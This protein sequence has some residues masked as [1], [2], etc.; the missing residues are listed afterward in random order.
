[1]DAGPD[2]IGWHLAHHHDITVSRATISRYL[3]KAGLVAPERR[4]APSR[5]TSG[6]RRRCPMRPGS[7]TSP[8]TG[9][10]TLPARQEPMQRSCPGSTTT[11][12]MRCT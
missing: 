5:P 7:P 11:P 8:T 4:S 1:L 3:T 6:S 12:A 10:P 2:T 9:A